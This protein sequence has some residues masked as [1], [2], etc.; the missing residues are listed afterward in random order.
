MTAACIP[1]AA[2]TTAPP[3]AC[4][5]TRLVTLE[6]LGWGARAI[7]LL[8]VQVDDDEVA[9]AS[10]AKSSRCSNVLGNLSSTEYDSRC[11]MYIHIASDAEE[12]ILSLRSDPIRRRISLGVHSPGSEYAGISKFGWYRAPRLR[13]SVGAISR[14][15]P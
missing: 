2:R 8:Q 1:M 15:P 11:C 10:I 9:V 14:N 7:G 13:P 6:A 3:P 4:L 12:N 5:P